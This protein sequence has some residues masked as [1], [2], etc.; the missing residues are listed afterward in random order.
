VRALLAIPNT[1]WA[2]LWSSNSNSH[3][4]CL[5]LHSCEWLRASSAFA[6]IVIFWGTR[7]T[8]GKRHCLIT[9]GGC[10]LLDSSCVVSIELSM[11]IVEELRCWL[12]GVRAYLIGAAKA[13][14][15]ESRYWVNS[16]P[17]GSKI[18]PSFD[19][20]ASESLNSTS[21]SIRGDRQITDTT[22]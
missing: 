17:L 11:K 10:H 19:R 4:R 8:P 22:E 13:M 9:L 12:W 14:I 7:C 15:V 3:T 6:S 2:H 16:C 21:T 1:H 18:K 5:R 20:K